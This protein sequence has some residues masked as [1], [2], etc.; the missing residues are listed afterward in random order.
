MVLL[1]GKH[2]IRFTLVFLLIFFSI[3]F[4]AKDDDTPGA[5][6]MA[7][8]LTGSQTVVTQEETEIPSRLDQMIEDAGNKYQVDPELIRLVIKQESGFKA[9]A[10][11]PKNAQGVMQTTPATAQRFGIK[12]TYDPKQSIEGGTR[13][14]KWLLEKFDDNVPLALAGY[15]AGENTVIR[16]GYKIPPYRETKEY[17]TR[18]TSAYGK[19]WHEAP[20]S[21]SKLK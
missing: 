11:S 18:I 4:I 10:R 1:Q 8:V 16:Y 5:S 15:N 3:P 21:L 14:L 12:N 13:Y 6:I 17:V 19:T 20:A 2:L 7:A 9:T